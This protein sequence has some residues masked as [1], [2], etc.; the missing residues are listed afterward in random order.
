MNKGQHESRKI[1]KDLQEAKPIN[2]E[3]GNGQEQ[4]T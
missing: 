2:K 1:N 4:Q 3:E